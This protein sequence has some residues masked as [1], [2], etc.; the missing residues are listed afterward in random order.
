MRK[1]RCIECKEGDFELCVLCY[2]ESV[3]D[4]EDRGCVVSEGGVSKQMGNRVLDFEVY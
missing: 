4:L 1:L 2:G 3:Q